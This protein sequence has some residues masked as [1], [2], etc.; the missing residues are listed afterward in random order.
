MFQNLIANVL[1]KAI[2]T[3]KNT[4]PRFACAHN[5][6]PKLN[7]PHQKHSKKMPLY[8]MEWKFKSLAG[9]TKAAVDKF[10]STG[11]PLGVTDKMIG[12]YHGPG[13][14]KG[15]IIV[16]T[17]NLHGLYEHAS[18]WSELLEWNITPVL[19]DQ[20]A[21]MICGKVWGTEETK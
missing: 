5:S 12:R 2:K 21:G 13:S 8:C 20:E 4:P 3:P 6:N 17:D 16:E 1:Y 15:W 11:A 9:T 14:Q 19:T 7:A 10:L 18:E